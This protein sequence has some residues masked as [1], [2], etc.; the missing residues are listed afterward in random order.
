M[1][2]ATTRGLLIAAAVFGG[3]LAG[4]N[5]DRA[6]VAMPAWER[7]GTQGWAEFSRYADLGN[8]LFLYPIEAIGGALLVL[9]AAISFH[10][11]RTAPPQAA[12]PLY[13][14]VL[15]AL[16]GLVLTLK[17]APIML[18]IRDMSD[19]AG[20]QA[21]FEGFRFWGNLRGACQVTTFLLEVWALGVLP[22]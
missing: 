5:I 19:P 9:A 11:D 16:A 4:G 20:L 6:L 21:S 13:A 22:R 8:G 18:G 2:S 3:V 14:A 17:A 10:F 15:L 1:A 12:V 7:V